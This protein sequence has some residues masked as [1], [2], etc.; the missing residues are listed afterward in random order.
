MIARLGL[1]KVPTWEIIVS[2]LLLILT[3]IFFIKLASK[4]FRVGML[5]YGKTAS[6]KE[7]WKWLKY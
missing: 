6:P 4:L 2:I 7:I 1:I 3:I 5:M